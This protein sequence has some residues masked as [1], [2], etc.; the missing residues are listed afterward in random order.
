M[1]VVA[2]R[3]LLCLSTCSSFSVG[4]SVRD[5][6]PY[7]CLVWTLVAI[8]WPIPGAGLNLSEVWTRLLHLL[9]G[10][11]VLYHLQT[12]VCMS[13]PCLASRSRRWWIGW[14]LKHSLGGFLLKL[15]PGLTNILLSTLVGA[16][17]SGN[18]L[19]ISIVGPLLHTSQVSSVASHVGQSQSILKSPG[20]WRQHFH[21]RP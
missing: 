3:R 4:L 18:Q 13:V 19:P 6:G 17:L 7:I 14:V 15:L 12:F 11:T 1:W 21:R 5:G 16:C 2:P 9:S 10:F 8:F 20:T